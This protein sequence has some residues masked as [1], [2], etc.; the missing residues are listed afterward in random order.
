PHY[1]LA[2]A[3]TIHKS[4]GSEY[5]HVYILIPNVSERN[6]KILNAELLYTAVTR[7]KNR[8]NVYANSIA[9]I[10]NIIARKTVRVT[11]INYLLN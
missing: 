4:Q 1:Q 11:G 7:A 3:I 9:E 10:K 2:F 8:V 6:Q 5:N